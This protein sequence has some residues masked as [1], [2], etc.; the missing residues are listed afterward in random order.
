MTTMRANGG[1]VRAWPAWLVLLV[2][3]AAGCGGAPRT[4]EQIRLVKRTLAAP[5]LNDT[6]VV[7]E[8]LEI[9]MSRD[10]YLYVTNPGLDKRRQRFDVEKADGVVEKTWSNLTG[11]RNAWFTVKISEPTD[12][13][14]PG[15]SKP[16]G[17]TYTVMSQF[18]LRVLER[19]DEPSLSARAFGGVVLVEAAG[20]PPEQP[21]EYTI[22]N[23]VLKR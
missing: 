17:T 18:T 4:P 12:P 23:G 19:A 14:Q 2:A 7:C 15:V 21:R 3:T 9:E 5:F 8:R 6:R 22:V 20:R 10:F 1:T 13:L 11:D 16:G